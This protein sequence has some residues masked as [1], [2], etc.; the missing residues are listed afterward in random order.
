VGRP[1]GVPPPGGGG[2]V[3]G[4]GGVG[5]GPLRAVHFSRHKW[6]GELVNLDS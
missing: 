1:P 4:G 6:P 3:G 2:P 5:S